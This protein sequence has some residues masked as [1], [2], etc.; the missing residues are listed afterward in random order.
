MDTASWVSS[1]VPRNGFNPLWE[2]TAEFE[3]TYPELALVEFKVKS[4][5]KIVGGQDD[6]LGSNM[7]SVSLVRTGYRHVSLETYEA[8]RLTPAS[9]FLRINSHQRKTARPA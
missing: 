8:T 2:E 3:I 5:A 7:I 4:K 1:V 6:H 9:L